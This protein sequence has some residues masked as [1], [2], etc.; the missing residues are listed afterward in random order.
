MQKE[1]LT[2]VERRNLYRALW[3]GM[4]LAIGMALT[5]PTTIIVAFISDL[6]GSQ[7]WVG[8]LTTLLTVAGALPQ[9]FVVCY[10]EPHLY[11]RP[12]LLVAIYLCIVSWGLL[13]ILVHLL[14]R[15]NPTLFTWALVGLL[16]VFYAG[17]GL[18]G[19][20]YTDIIGKIIPAHRRG[21][22]FATREALVRPF[23]VGAALLALRAIP[24]PRHS[25]AQ[26]ASVS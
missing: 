18:G 20:P 24:D 1:T 4:F 15:N 2:A 25:A 9:I 8:G 12:M 3:H 23:A 7:L 19:V 22:F 11:K 5:R 14:G 26:V 21:A 6:T 17:G 13:A 16:A 10:I